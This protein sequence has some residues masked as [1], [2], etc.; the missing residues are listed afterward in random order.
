MEERVGQQRDGCKNG[1]RTSKAARM[2]LFVAATS[3][4][5]SWLPLTIASASLITGV[6]LA[7]VV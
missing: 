3:D 1:A 6:N 7:P 2:A 4:M 5:V